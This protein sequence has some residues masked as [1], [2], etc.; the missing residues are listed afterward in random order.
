MT[1]YLICKDCYE[2]SFDVAEK[3]MEEFA[4]H[5]EEIMTRHAWTVEEE[6][7]AGAKGPQAEDLSLPEGKAGDDYKYQLDL[8]ESIRV[9]LLEAG[10]PEDHIEVTDICTMCNPDLLFSHR[11]TKGE[12]GVG[13]AFLALKE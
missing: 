13:A 7:S 12:R 4:G 11:Y 5:E 10:V 6:E 3:F 9:T 8:W 1:K 2:V